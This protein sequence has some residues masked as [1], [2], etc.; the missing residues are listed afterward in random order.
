ML[1]IGI[2]MAG[3]IVFCK[4]EQHEYV[5]R[6]ERE[7]LDKLMGVNA[8][9]LYVDDLPA[10]YHHFYPQIKYAT[11]S[12]ESYV[13]KKNVTVLMPYQT[14][15]QELFD[16][17]FEITQISEKHVL[18]SN[19]EKMIAALKKQGYTFYH[20]YPYP[21]LVDL[22]EEAEL[23]DLKMTKDGGCIVKGENAS[24]L[25]GPYCWL[26]AGQYEVVYKLRIKNFERNT[27]ICR[28]QINAAYGQEFVA[29]Q[30]INSDMADADGNI[31]VSMN[32]NIQQDSSVIEFLI[33]GYGENRVEIKEIGYW[34]KYE[35][36]SINQYN[37][38]HLV[39]LTK[40]Y[41]A[42]NDAPYAVDDGYYAVGKKYDSRNRVV[43][44]CYYDDKLQITNAETGFAITRYQYETKSGAITYFYYNRNELPVIFDGGYSALKMTYFEHGGEKVYLNELGE[45]TTLSYGY[46]KEKWII[47]ESGKEIER[48]FY[49]ATGEL[50]NN[51]WG[52]AKV[53]KE[54]NEQGLIEKKSLYDTYGNPV[55]NTEGYQ[56]T[57]WEYNA[58]GEIA[59]MSEYDVNGK[60]IGEQVQN[61]AS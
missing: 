25:H 50:V 39:E 33:F 16:A 42:D 6:S 49:S 13:S 51:I 47:N 19:N 59:R 11:G 27:T 61:D 10:F 28:A 15:N 31:T 4:L 36:V 40:Y 52:Y 37:G 56:C 3:S 41:S 23:N 21:V 7:A 35:Y 22:E 38:K 17:G 1:L 8:G 26:D 5:V 53:L 14:N 32:F 44:Q 43:E 29:S 54:Y 30:E 20:Y 48:T 34:K 9:K 24:L 46:S 18:Y 2:G 55:N 58:N 60:P 57:V 45:E 12:G